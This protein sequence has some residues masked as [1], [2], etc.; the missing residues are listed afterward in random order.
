[1]WTE[2][3][4]PPRKGSSLAGIDEI[5]GFAAEPSVEGAHVT[6]GSGMADRGGPVTAGSPGESGGKVCE[7]YGKGFVL[8]IEVEPPASADEY[9][10]IE[11]LSLNGLGNSTPVGDPEVFASMTTLGSLQS[12]TSATPSQA[13][14]PILFLLRSSTYCS[15]STA[16]AQMC[17]QIICRGGDWR[18]WLG[19]QV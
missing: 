18:K 3:R 7:T 13:P 16:Q 9:F 1:M 12:R 14:T 19:V 10:G 5:L 15:A 8:K 11:A 2:T 6:L 17:G 4:S